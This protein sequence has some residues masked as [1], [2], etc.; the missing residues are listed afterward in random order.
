[1]K[2][3]A[4]DFVNKKMLNKTVDNQDRIS[5]QI[6]VA[7]RSWKGDFFINEDFGVDYDFCWHDMQLMKA[8]IVQQI[9]EVSGVLGVNSVTVRKEEETESRQPYFVIDAEVVLDDNSINILEA[10]EV[11]L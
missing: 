1:M 7:V 10:I 4:L 8:Y 3:I 9:I 2:D 6:K 11:N 5:Q